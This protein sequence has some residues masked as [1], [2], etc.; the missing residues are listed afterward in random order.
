MWN[1][2]DLLVTVLFEQMQHAVDVRYQI[3][4][5]YGIQFNRDLSA[6][7]ES[8]N[9]DHH[10]CH[11]CNLHRVPVYNASIFHWRC[12]RGFSGSVPP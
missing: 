4:E 8:A 5:A 11:Q 7:A 10:C 12:S 6:K 2:I 1:K 9:T 3:V